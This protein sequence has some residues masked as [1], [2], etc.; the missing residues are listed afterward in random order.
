MIKLLLILFLNQFSLK[1]VFSSLSKDKI[2]INKT[3]SNQESE[4]RSLL[5]D[6]NKYINIQDSKGWTALHWSAIFQNFK[7]ATLLIE[8]QANK[9]IKDEENRT[10]FELALIIWPETK[11]L[12]LLLKPD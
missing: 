6:S 12:H 7:I 11:R 5:Q 9:Q 8:H 3:K 10:A 1:A 4:L 2:I